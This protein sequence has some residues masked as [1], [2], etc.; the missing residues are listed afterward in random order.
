MPPPVFI[1][2]NAFRP[3][4]GAF[5]PELGLVQN[6][7]PA[8]AG[9]LSLRRKRALASVSDGPMTGAYVHIYQQVAQIQ[10]ARPDGDAI[11]GTWLADSG[12]V[13]FSRVNEATPSDAEYI[14]AGGA[15]AAQ[16]VKLS[17]SDITDPTSAADH[18]LRWRYRIPVTPSGAWTV[19]AQLVEGTT[20]RATDTATGSA[21]TAYVQREYTLTAGEANAITDYANLFVVFTAT[22][23]GAAQFARPS[24]DT[25]V[26]GWTT[27]AGGSTNLYQGLDETSAS[28]ADYAQSPT[29]A[30]GGAAYVYGGTLSAT[31]DP[32]TDAGLTFRFRY[33][34]TNAGVTIKARLKQGSTLVKEVVITAAALAW[35]TS[36][37]ALSTAEAALITDYAALSFEAE[38]SY[39]ASVT[40]TASQFGRPTSDANNDSQF[41]TFA[42]G[43]TNLFQQ[44]DE[45]VA[46]DSDGFVSNAA[47]GGSLDNFYE[48]SLG[49]LAAPA[50]SAGHV[51]RFRWKRASTGSATILV[52]LFQGANLIATAA[53]NLN[54]PS[55]DSTWTT[56]TYTLTAGEVSLITNYADLRLRFTHPGLFSI[57]EAFNVSWT[58]FEAPKPRQAQVSWLELETPSASRAEVSWTEFQVPGVAQ[59]YR[60]DV[61][62]IITGSKTKLYEASSSGFTDI[63]IAANYGAGAKPGAWRIGSFGNDVIATNRADPVQ[64][65]AGN[66]GLFADLITS[67]LKPKARFG[68][69]VRD[70]WVLADINLTGYFPDGVWWSQFNN[71]RFFDDQAVNF[72]PETQ[73]DQQRIVSCPGQIMG[74]VGGDYGVIFKRN[75]MHLMGWVGGNLVFRFDDISRAVGTPYPSSIVSTPYGVFWFDGATFRRYNGGTGEQSIADVGTGILSEFLTD[76]AFSTAA[77][78]Q[79][80]PEDISVEDQIMIGHWDPFARLIIWV[81]QSV[82]FTELTPA[83]PGLPQELETVTPLPY[84]HMRGI[85]YNPQEDRWVA[86]YDRELLAAVMACKPNVTNSDAYLLKGTAGFDWDG[87]TTSFFQFDG[88]DTYEGT[89]NSKRQA[90]GIED[91][92]E[93]EKSPQAVRLKG[94]LPIFSHVPLESTPPNLSVSVTVA[95][96]PW[97]ISGRQVK[98]ADVSKAAISTGIMP[99]DVTGTWFLFSVTIPRLTAQAARAFRGIYVWWDYA[100]SPGGM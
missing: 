14:F 84:Q 38:A 79:I 63:S 16:A 92:E 78:A 20:V 27:Q 11:S 53:N 62:T 24:A 67:S 13:L 71:A 37:T 22:V 18:F 40:S 68:A 56:V 33:Q 19:T 91:V 59:V 8:H 17:L 65:R 70:H 31:T 55:T 96:D 30:A 6:Y 95:N 39:P 34:A 57:T 83:I 77:I 3:D 73:S 81:Y 86:L 51:V 61:P 25:S 74:L 54:K 49:A 5:G 41:Q 32:A 23:P 50:T 29:L 10:T 2:F 7:L 12:A 42:G 1:S 15:P 48:A 85:A 75:S 90:L 94:I 80:E 97:M 88:T 98:T 52:Q 60:G 69:A 26:G 21:L 66:T 4:G 93:P 9:W 45:T 64:Y 43:T 100:G 87:V 28:D 72:S 46:S 99:C 44:V 76:V 47:I 89:F 82:E 36:A 35:T 58:E